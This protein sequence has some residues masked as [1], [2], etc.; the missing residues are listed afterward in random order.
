MVY[1]G[2]ALS[3]SYPSAY[4]IDSYAGKFVSTPLTGGAGS[5]VVSSN[6]KEAA[7]SADGSRF[8]SASGAPYQCQVWAVGNGGYVGTLPGG[9]AYP[10]NV[11]VGSDGRI[12]CGISGWYSQTDVWMYG[13]A[14]DLRA[15]Y[16]FAGYGR[17]LLDRQFVVSGDGL[18]GVA[19]T[20]DPQLVFVPV[21]P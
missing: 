2:N 8:Y 13:P 20:D 10:N 4:A 18:V 15:T 12:F 14:G 17:G 6:G 7:I 11:K 3:P 5:T 19:Q 9:D 16:K 21:G 1:G